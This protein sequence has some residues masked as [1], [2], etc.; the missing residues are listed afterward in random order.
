M[1]RLADDISVSSLSVKFIGPKRCTS[2]CHVPQ[3]LAGAEG[4]REESGELDDFGS[5]GDFAPNSLD[6]LRATSTASK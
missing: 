2:R 4:G 1:F 3:V 6:R 5:L